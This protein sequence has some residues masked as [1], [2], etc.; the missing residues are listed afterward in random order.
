MHGDRLQFD[1]F[2]VHRNTVKW[3]LFDAP[4]TL[5]EPRNHV[6]NFRTTMKPEITKTRVA[7]REISG[8]LITFRFTK[9]DPPLASCT[10]R[11]LLTVISDIFWKRGLLV[12]W[13]SRDVV[14]DVVTLFL[15]VP[16]Q[17]RQAEGPNATH[18]RL[19]QE[20]L[21]ELTERLPVSKLFD[22]SP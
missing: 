18:V 21:R 10:K 20:T 12:V 5:S 16:W 22:L 2:S 17:E 14:L 11:R 8:R 7:D 3:Q 19:L 4:R 13:P 9:S 1:L 6:L 15:H